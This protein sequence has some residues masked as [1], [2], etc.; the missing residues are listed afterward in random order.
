MT[1]R[2]LSKKFLAP[3]GSSHIDSK[4]DDSFKTSGTSK[5]ASDNA[6]TLMMWL[7]TLMM[8]VT[9]L[10]MVLTTLLM[11]LMSLQRADD[12]SLHYISYITIMT[13]SQFS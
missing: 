6:I 4:A 13:V 3:K 9:M 5:D 12:A 10:V 2:K 7:V 1:L 11:L 8:P